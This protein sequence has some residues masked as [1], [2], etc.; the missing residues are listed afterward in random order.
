[1]KFY[2]CKKCNKTITAMDTDSNTLNCCSEQM[3]ELIPGSV[4]AA[5]EKHIPV[6]SKENGY[7]VTVG[8]IEHPMTTEHYI[9]WIAFELDDGSVKKMNLKPN[10]KPIA[11]LETEQ[12]VKAVYAYCN[13][14]GLWKVE[15]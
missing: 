4:E 5:K 1:M 11:H 12:K 9:E 2:K 13:L 7:F 10:E 8:E 15:I 3:E 14:H 6:V